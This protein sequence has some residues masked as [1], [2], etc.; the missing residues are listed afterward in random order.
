MQQL[1]YKVI[2]MVHAALPGAELHLFCDVMWHHKKIEN[3][4]ILAMNVQFWP[5]KY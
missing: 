5:Q 2:N 3:T 1:I 4:I